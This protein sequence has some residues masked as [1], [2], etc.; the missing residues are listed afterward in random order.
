MRAGR[1]LVRHRGDGAKRPDA[2]VEGQLDDDAGRGPPVQS[3]QFSLAGSLTW[4]QGASQGFTSQ[5]DTWTANLTGVWTP[6]KNFEFRFGGAVGVLTGG[7]LS[8]ATLGSGLSNRGR[9]HRHL[10]RRSGLFAE[11][12]GGAPLLSGGRGEAVEALGFRP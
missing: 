11:R 12:V 10:R 7:S 2:A 8:T 1:R 9:L 6:H 4:D 3:E 5:T